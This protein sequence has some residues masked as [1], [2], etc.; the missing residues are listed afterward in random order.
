MEDQ[1]LVVISRGDLD[2]ALQRA[3]EQAVEV[4][5]PRAL[6]TLGFDISKPL[7]VQKDQ[8]YLRDL[9]TG[10]RASRIALVG[11]VIAS[12]VTAL[13]TLLWLGLQAAFGGAPPTG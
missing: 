8:A 3:A 1:E 6:T 2:A 13:G 4:A 10:S 12:G 9:R 5:L 7:E 11:A